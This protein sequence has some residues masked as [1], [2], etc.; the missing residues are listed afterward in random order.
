MLAGIAG[1]FLAIP[2]IAI[3]K[4]IF[5]NIP[6]LEPWGYLI[7]DDL[8]KIPQWYKKVPYLAKV[9]DGSTRTLAK[10]PAFTKTTT[11]VELEVE[12]SENDTEIEAEQ[13]DQNKPNSQE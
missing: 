6:S 10:A 7:G 12:S 5:D 8:P 3:L 9:E 4:V 2:I 11:Q 13:D 1:M